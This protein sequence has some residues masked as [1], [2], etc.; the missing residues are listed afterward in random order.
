MEEGGGVRQRGMEGG[1]GKA[2]RDGGGRGKAK[3]DGGGRGNTKREME[4]GGVDGRKNDEKMNT[5]LFIKVYSV[6]V[7]V[8]AI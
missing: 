5:L 6:G 7:G 3:R 2:K 4:E 1:R 8:G